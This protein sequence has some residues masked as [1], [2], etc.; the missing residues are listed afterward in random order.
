MKLT[1][2][3]RGAMT[4]PLNAIATVADFDSAG[5]VNRDRKRPADLTH[6]GVGKPAKAADQDCD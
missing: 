4:S 6:P 3:Y 1:Q 2:T 5:A